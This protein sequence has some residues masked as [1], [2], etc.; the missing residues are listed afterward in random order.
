MRSGCR[1]AVKARQYASNAAQLA[2]SVT[3]SRSSAF[4][5]VEKYASS[6]IEIAQ[7]R[8]V[9]FPSC[10]NRQPSP[11]LIVVSVAP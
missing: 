1:S 2:S 4:V 8:S 3:Q 5:G 7:A 6:S 9:N 11:W 10:T